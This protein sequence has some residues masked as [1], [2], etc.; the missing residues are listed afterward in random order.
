MGQAMTWEQRREE[1]A[2]TPKAQRPKKGCWWCHGYGLC[3]YGKARRT[4]NVP[5]KDSAPCEVCGQR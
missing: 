4:M 3:Y 5:T 2:R 1:W